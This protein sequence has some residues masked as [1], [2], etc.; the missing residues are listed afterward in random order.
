MMDRGRGRFANDADGTIVRIDHRE[1]AQLRVAAKQ[2]DDRGHMRVG[3]DRGRV[4]RRR[5]KSMSDGVHSI[6][7]KL[8]RGAR[9]D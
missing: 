2:V 5:L 1:R 8:R 4:A 6:L 9:L 7:F 3:A